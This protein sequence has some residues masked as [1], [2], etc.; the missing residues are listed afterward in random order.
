MAQDV[1]YSR[2]SDIPGLIF[3]TAQFAE[4]RPSLD[5]HIALAASPM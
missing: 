5:C 3:S 2:P 1:Q 4:Y